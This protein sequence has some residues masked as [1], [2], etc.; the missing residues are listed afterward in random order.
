MNKYI[1]II[2]ILITIILYFRYIKNKKEKYTEADTNINSLIKILLN[3][4]ISVLDDNNVVIMQN[5]GIP[6][7]TDP[8]GNITIN[9]KPIS[10]DLC[11]NI[12]INNSKPM[13][14]DNSGNIT[15]GDIIINNNNNSLSNK[16]MDYINIHNYVTKI[17]LQ[18]IHNDDTNQNI[19]DKSSVNYLSCANGNTLKCGAF[20]TYDCGVAV[21]VNTSNMKYSNYY[22]DLIKYPLAI[23]GIK[24]QDINEEDINFDYYTTTVQNLT[25]ST[26]IEITSENLYTNLIN[27]TKNFVGYSIT[28][29]VPVNGDIHSYTFTFIEPQ[30]IKNIV[31][32]NRKDGFQN[33]LNYATLLIYGK[34]LNQEVLLKSISLNNFDNN[35]YYTP[36]TFFTKSIATTTQ[37]PLTVNLYP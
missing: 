4:K 35:P 18:K 6:I 12:I 11:G 36:G 16:N 1:I 32:A 27:S 15:V 8:S 9:S 13:N 26:S 24:F 37:T 34:K 30:L 5:N 3:N 21:N 25:Q 29:P 17:V 14:V 33:A 19:V 28:T 7:T 10:T 31:I 2:I 23:S 20:S 22:N